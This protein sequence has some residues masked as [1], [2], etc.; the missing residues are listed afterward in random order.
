[1]PGIQM[2]SVLRLLILSIGMLAT[3]CG[4]GSDRPETANV[5]GK[6]TLDGKPLPGY[7]VTFQ[8]TS[9]RPSVSNMPTNAEGR[10]EL[11]YTFRDKGAKVGK[12]KVTLAFSPTDDDAAIEAEAGR[13]TGDAKQ[14]AEK[15]G[16][17]DVPPLEFAV[18]KDTTDANF[19]I[20]LD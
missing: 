6:L 18:T 9:G 8:P 14:I 1:M 11:W 12:H 3:G 7:I 2:R 20:K 16:T 5:S 17:L 10:F 19:D 15:Y 4:G 13:V